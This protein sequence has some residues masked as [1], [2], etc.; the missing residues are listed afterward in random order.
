MT[1]GELDEQLDKIQQEISVI[2]LNVRAEFTKLD[3]LRRR[4]RN[5]G[6][7]DG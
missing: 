7:S 2:V 6:I 3:M 5:E 4:I 1:P